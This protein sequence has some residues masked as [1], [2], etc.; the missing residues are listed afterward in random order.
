MI[1]EMGPARGG[2][3][4]DDV[5][6]DDK[7]A[8]EAPIVRMANAIIVQA[9]EQGASDIHIEPDR[10]AVRIRYRIDGVCTRR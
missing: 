5:E 9:I 10:R 6:A 2:G 7:A 3:G 1:A 4:D 8:N